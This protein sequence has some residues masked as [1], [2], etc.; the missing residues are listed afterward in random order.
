MST[1]IEGSSESGY[2]ASGNVIRKLI[3]IHT[4]TLSSYEFDLGSTTL[5]ASGS[6]DGFLIPPLLSTGSMNITTA[7]GILT[8]LKIENLGSLNIPLSLS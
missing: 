2:T 3:L 5:S 4:G 6:W 7:S 8:A 1:Y